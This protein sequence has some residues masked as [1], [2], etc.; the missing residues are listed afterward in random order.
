ML[1]RY[2]RCKINVFSAVFSFN[3]AFILSALY[4]DR[5]LLMLSIMEIWTFTIF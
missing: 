2:E 5:Q 3:L 1:Q 4:L